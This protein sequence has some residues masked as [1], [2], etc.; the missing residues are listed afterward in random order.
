VNFATNHCWV[1]GSALSVALDVV[2]LGFT[3]QMNG[4]RLQE[5]LGAAIASGI[6]YGL[7]NITCQ[8][9][10]TLCLFANAANANVLRSANNLTMVQSQGCS[11]LGRNALTPAGN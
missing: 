1:D 11:G 5:A 2:A 7:C 9:L 10:S 3:L 4:N 6:A 8:N